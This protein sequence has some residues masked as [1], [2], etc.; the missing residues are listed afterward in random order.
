MH[1]PDA[2]LVVMKGA[3]LSEHVNS[4][5]RF[6]F[7]AV[8]KRGSPLPA[9]DLFRRHQPLHFQTALPLAVTRRSCDKKQ[10]MHQALLCRRSS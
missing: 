10:R 2:K 5:I 6:A 7:C 4:S 3:L 1:P 8:Q 9:N